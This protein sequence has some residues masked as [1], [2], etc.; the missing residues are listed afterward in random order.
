MKSVVNKIG[1]LIVAFLMAALFIVSGFMVYA[2]PEDTGLPEGFEADEELNRDLNLNKYG[3]P[4]HQ[5]KNVFESD[6]A[7]IPDIDVMLETD[8]DEP[9]PLD[10]PVP[11]RIYN[12]TTQRVEETVI[13]EEGKISGLKLR[14]GHAYTI[15]SADEHYIIFN[16][17]IPGTAHKYY[18]WALKAGDQGVSADGAYDYKTDYD[19]DNSKSYLRM[20]NEI[21]VHY[22]SS[23]FHDPLKYTMRLPVTFNGEPA[24]GVK[25]ILT[26]ESE[27]PVNAVSS[28]GQLEAELTEDTDYTVHIDDPAYGIETLAVAVKDKSEHKYTDETT[29]STSVYGRY[30]Y[31]H[32]CCQ[33]LNEFKLLTKQ[34]A[35]QTKSGKINS[36]RK[37]TDDK[38]IDQPLVTVTGMNFKTLLL[39]VRNIAVQMPAELADRDYDAID[40][41]YVNP[42][43]W[44]LCKITDVD[45]TVTAKLPQFRNL[46]GVYLL[47]D[48]NAEPISFT[49]DYDH[50]TFHMTSTVPEPVVM[51]YGD[52][53]PKKKPEVKPQSDNNV[54]VS[55]PAGTKIT[56]L[57]KG[58]K[59]LTVTWKKQT[60]G[61]TG[62]K[63]QY[64]TS[65]NFKKGCKTITVKGAGKTKYTIKK[66]KSKKKYYV[67]IR[68]YRIYG[69]KT[70]ASRWSA[71]KAVKVK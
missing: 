64:S 21:T 52:G 1:V 61:T 38:G 23:G 35:E 26:S 15:T 53:V 62:Y 19:G 65:K 60:K 20:L 24:D 58:K 51:V 18:V 39:L 66:L 46:A 44:E 13:A 4:V 6:L 68:T 17:M 31:D 29:G 67:R 40:L 55:A 71:A 5:F 36:L 33:G 2:A 57:T 47:R 28:N 37:Y 32:T 49:Q 27:D 7:S 63:I 69:G 30:T 8:Y 50:V 43:R 25:F 34:A 54:R 12:C 10:E 70:L 16:Y 56:K 59:K 22:S 48:G 41:T 9:Y 14:H 11:F 45:L 42:H 3:V